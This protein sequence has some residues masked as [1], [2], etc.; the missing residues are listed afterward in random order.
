MGYYDVYKARVNAFGDTNQ[1]RVINESK[2]DFERFLESSP[3]AAKIYFKDNLYEC[4]IISSRQDDSKTLHKLLIDSEVEITSGDLIQWNHNI[5]EGPLEHWIILRQQQKVFFAYRKYYMVR[6][7]KEVSW[8]DEY[9]VVKTNYCYQVSSVDKLIKDYFPDNS[10]SITYADFNQ[11]ISLLIPYEDFKKETRFIIGN[12]AWKVVGFDKTSVPGIVYLTLKEDFINNIND[13]LIA[14]GDI[15]DLANINLENLYQIKL[16]HED[17]NLLVD[18]NFIVAPKLFKDG[19]EIVNPQF[20]YKIDGEWVL[21][22]INKLTAS[23]Y[24]FNKSVA[25]A[26]AITVAF[27]EQN[28]LVKNFDI[29]VIESSQNEITYTIEGPEIIRWGQQGNY[30]VYKYSDGVEAVADAVF[31][32]NNSLGIL[33]V[34]DD[35]ECIIIGNS[36]NKTGEITLSVAIDSETLTKTIKVVSLW[37][38]I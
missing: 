22:G 18:T 9:G 2:I 8:I 20:N 27:S 30:R 29:N 13:D 37:Q 33:T 11:Y 14:E 7:N 6:C 23:T 35:D 24:T 10:E 1:E 34:I 15:R 17:I 21:D 26:Y 19:F 16:T 25:N 32:I 36:N 28:D 31:T 3:S 38:V 12:Q 5:V 4:A